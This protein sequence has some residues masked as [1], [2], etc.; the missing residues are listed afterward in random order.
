M[1]RASC[2]AVATYDQSQKIEAFAVTQKD[3]VQSC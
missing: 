2:I 3:G 1:E